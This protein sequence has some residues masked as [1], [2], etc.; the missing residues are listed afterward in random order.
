MKL[1]TQ[2]IELLLLEQNLTK[3]ALAAKS[4]ISRQNI[5]TILGRG[6]C[7]PRTA[8]KLAKGLNVDAS[9]IIEIE[10]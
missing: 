2:K 1:N 5:S 4:G 10:K 7:E 9:E 8:A 3:T 6:T